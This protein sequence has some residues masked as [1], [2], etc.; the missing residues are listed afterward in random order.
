M[1]QQAANYNDNAS[2]WMQQELHSL[3]YQNRSVSIKVYLSP[4]AFYT[5]APKGAAQLCFYYKV[6]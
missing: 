5:A 1:T 4:G 2:Y 3:N 6:T